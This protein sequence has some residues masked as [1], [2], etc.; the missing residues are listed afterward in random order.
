MSQAHA[1]RSAAHYQNHPAEHKP[2]QAHDKILRLAAWRHVASRV[3]KL[4]HTVLTTHRSTRYDP[5]PVQ[6]PGQWREPC[7]NMKAPVDGRL[8][9]LA[10]RRL[11]RAPPSPLDIIGANLDRVLWLLLCCL[12]CEH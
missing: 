7:Q 5:G 11:Q 4:C 6:R 8:Y 3:P 2:E 10:G 12:A 9:A 1:D